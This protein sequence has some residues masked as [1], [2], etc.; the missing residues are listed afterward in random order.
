MSQALVSSS[1]AVSLPTIVI[2]ERAQL[3][4]LEFFTANIRNLTRGGLMR[5][6]CMNF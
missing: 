3:R 2:G 4:F 6:P 5:E 1:S